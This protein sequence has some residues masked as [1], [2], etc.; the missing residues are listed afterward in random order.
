MNSVQQQLFSSSCNRV[1]QNNVINTAAVSVAYD[2]DPL[3]GRLVK[4]KIPGPK[5]IAYMARKS[6]AVSA[7]VGNSVP[8]FMEEAYGAVV[9]DVDG[10]RYIDMVW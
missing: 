7:G 3:P 4:T 10:N 8:I 9:Q 6:A 5:S 1:N 2:V